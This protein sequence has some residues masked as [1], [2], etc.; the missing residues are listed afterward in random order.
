MIG[1][2]NSTCLMQIMSVVV[3]VL[4]GTGYMI[5]CPVPYT[6]C[7]GSCVDLMTDPDNCGAC[8]TACTGGKHCYNGN[9]ECYGSLADCMG[10]CFDLQKDPDHCGACDYSCDPGQTCSA[11]TCFSESGAAVAEVVVY[12]RT[13][14]SGAVDIYYSVIDPCDWSRVV[15]VAVSDDEGGSW[16]VPVVTLEGDAGRGVRPGL[17]HIVWLAKEDVPRMY[18]THFRVRVIAGE[19]VSKDSNTFM[20]NNLGRECPEMDM[21][22]D[23]LVNMKDL[24]IVAS[25]WLAPF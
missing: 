7:N 14:G 23:C 25:Q 9:C 15:V 18:G 3:V 16:N 10:T 22:D 24:A 1:K 4:A 17:K 21:N 13:D 20:I 19:L 8:G 2:N 12:Q 5:A 6:N 11:G